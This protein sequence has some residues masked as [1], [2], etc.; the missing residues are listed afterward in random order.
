MIKP[1]STPRPRRRDICLEALGKDPSAT[2]H[3]VTVEPA[4]G[5]YQSHRL[6]RDGKIRQTSMITTVYPLRSCSTAWT[7]T[8]H[9]RRS[10]SEYYRVASRSCLVDDKASGH[11]CGG[12]K[13]M[14]HGADSFCKPT[15]AD[16]QNSSK[17][18]Q[19]QF[20]TPKHTEANSSLHHSIRPRPKQ[21]RSG[22]HGRLA[23]AE[24]DHEAVGG[25]TV[26]AAPSHPAFVGPTS[27]G[28]ALI[29]SPDDHPWKFP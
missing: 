7:R 26:W 12:A 23:G 3:C 22:G 25:V 15:P 24:V 4:C 16:A 20:C 14:N 9:I 11:E 10:D 28:R 6:S 13:R 8:G 17:V 19:S 27:P 21:D 29:F 5:N 18:S 1:R 2:Q